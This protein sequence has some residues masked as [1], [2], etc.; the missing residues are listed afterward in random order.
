MFVSEELRKNNIAE[1]LL[2]MWQVEDSVRAV[3]LDPERLYDAV[4]KSSGRPEKECQTWKQWYADIADMMRR[5]GKVEKGHLQVNENVLVMLSDLHT[6][7][8]DSGKKQEYS[9]AYYKALP[10]I[11]EFRAKNHSAGNNELYDCFELMYGV[12]MLRLQKKTVG[13]ATAQAVDTISRMI[14]MLASYYRED[15]EGRLDLD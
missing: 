7:L 4:I 2:Y 11:V 3:G 9:D 14:A 6:R 5:E 12:W 1:Y 15:K 13:D 8:L 10:F